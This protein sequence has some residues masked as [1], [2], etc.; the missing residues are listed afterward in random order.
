MRKAQRKPLAV[1]GAL[2][3][4]GLAV[5]AVGLVWS[6]VDSKC[7]FSD[8]VRQSRCLDNLT[9][10]AK[11]KEEYRAMHNMTNGAVVATDEFIEMIEGGWPATACPGG[12]SYVIGPLGEKPA[13]AVHGVAP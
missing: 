2:F 1:T 7:Y 3:T 11:G 5:G 9:R 12:A 8:A 6:Y 13:C 4:A 10:V